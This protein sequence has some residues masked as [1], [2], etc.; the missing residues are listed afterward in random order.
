MGRIRKTANAQAAA[1]YGPQKRTTR[2]EGAAAVRSIRSIQQPLERGLSNT[3]RQLR[4]AG[5]SPRD[6][7]IALLGLANQH[8]DVAS[9]VA[10]QST[11]AQKATQAALVDL[12]QS[13]GQAAAANL[14]TLQHEAATH[15]QD[16]HD[17]I[18]AE[19]RGV[20]SDLL[21]EELQQKLGLG[22][23]RN[24]GKT[25]AE[26][27]SDA[28]SHHNAAFYAKQ[29]VEASKHGVVGEVVNPQT[30]NKEKKQ[31]VPPDPKTWNDQV[32]NHLA[33]QVASEKG[34]DSTAA[35]Q[36]AVTAIR[37]HFQ[38]PQHQTQAGVLHALG[39]VVGAAAPAIPVLS[40]I[41][42]AGAN[43][44]HRR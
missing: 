33:Q 42:Q 43:L 27:R 31:I 44:E 29:L 16:V 41:L 13:E 7:Q 15:R 6:L 30:G 28:E 19:A 35:A 12:N 3:G 18:A 38:G 1:Q 8:A 21:K 23:W 20:K 32:W 9:S 17:E 22:D 40:Q 36:K 2:R 25:A 26:A 10:L 37:E 5:L 34:V 4:H 14:A 11:E 39:T 24:G